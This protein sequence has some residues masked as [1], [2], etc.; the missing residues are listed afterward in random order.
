MKQ[1]G[2]VA[3]WLNSVAYSHSQSEAT[4]RR[5]KRLF[6]EFT[7]FKGMEAEEIQADYDILNVRKFGRK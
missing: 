2:F 4:V 6:T 5:Y 3:N 1:S 7:S